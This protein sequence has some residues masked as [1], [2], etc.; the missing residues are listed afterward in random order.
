[1]F[2]A[3]TRN[4]GIML[5]APFLYELWLVRESILSSL[6]QFC[7]G[8]LPMLLIPLG[9]LLYALY[10]WQL[11]GNPLMFAATQS[12]W[13]RQLSAPWQAFIQ[14]FF[15]LFMHQPFGSFN[16]VHILIDFTAA[17]VFIALIIVGRKKL[18]TSYTIWGALLILSFLID[19]S[20]W[21]RDPLI[22]SR[23]FVL[24]IFPAFI[25]L[26]MLSINRPRLHQT[27]L[28]V[29]PGLLAVFSLLFVMGKWMV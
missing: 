24:E 4:T 19:P 7:K 9:T 25:T 14:T 3:L 5:C 15:E 17:V 29:F 22:S 26:A 10:N 1:M 16:Q 27:L 23:R 28:W 12:H 20:I 6:R 18:R 13:S 8:A 11:T 2:A 21:Q